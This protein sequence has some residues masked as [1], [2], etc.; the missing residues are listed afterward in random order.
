M[1]ISKWKQYSRWVDIKQLNVCIFRL[2]TGE[3]RRRSLTSQVEKRHVP[4][5][6][7][8]V[9]FGCEIFRAV[10][11]RSSQTAKKITMYAGIAIS[12]PALGKSRPFLR[13][14]TERAER[15]FNWHAGSEYW[16]NQ[17]CNFDYIIRCHFGFSVKCR[18][19][20]SGRSRSTYVFIM[21]FSWIT[22]REKSLTEFGEV[23]FNGALL[24]GKT[25]EI[26]TIYELRS[27]MVRET[28]LKKISKM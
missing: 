12:M 8:D 14:M 28:R 15:R 16:H 24:F 10:Q 27:K 23:M 26:R 17:V 21:A 6:W 7:F 11:L 1:D 4:V 19:L 2:E 5:E 20:D 3:Y 25:A 18:K 22:R 13:S 9:Y